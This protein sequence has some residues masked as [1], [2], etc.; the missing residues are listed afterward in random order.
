MVTPVAMSIDADLVRR[1]S[2][3]LCRLPAGGAAEAA[4]ALGL[5]GSLVRRVDATLVEPPPPGCAELMLVE[6]NRGVDHLDL[7]LGDGPGGSRLTRAGLDARFGRGD[8]LVRIHYDSPYP[9]AY[10]VEVPG[11]PFTCE[12]IAYFRDE[13]TDASTA[14]RLV[15]RRDRA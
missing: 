8:E 12:V 15:L 11:A 4:M 14:V 9:L 3:R 7:E 1:W 10:H 2:E 6:G 13:P 5:A